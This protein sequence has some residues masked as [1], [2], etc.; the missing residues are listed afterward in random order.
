MKEGTPGSAV[1]RNSMLCA[2]N[3][4]GNSDGDDFGQPG[5][6]WHQEH[7][8]M[9]FLERIGKGPPLGKRVRRESHCQGKELGQ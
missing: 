8:R 7:T 4:K 2:K 1:S 3:R 5:T 9:W 6:S